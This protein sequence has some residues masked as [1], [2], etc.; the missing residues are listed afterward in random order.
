MI[1]IIINQFVSY[2]S[3]ESGKKI[4]KNSKLPEL[5]DGDVVI[6]LVLFNQMSKTKIILIFL[7]L[8]TKKGSSSSL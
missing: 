6:M 5:W 4:I 8:N 1:T 3:N 2:F 7:Y